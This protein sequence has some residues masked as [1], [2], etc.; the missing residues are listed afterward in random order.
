MEKHDPSVF[1][2]SGLVIG[3]TRVKKERKGKSGGGR[4]ER[5]DFVWLDG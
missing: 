2:F 1:F 3:E 5:R 4:E